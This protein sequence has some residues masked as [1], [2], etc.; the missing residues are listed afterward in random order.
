MRLLFL[1][2]SLYTLTASAQKEYKV[3]SNDSSAYVV[4]DESA[5]FHRMGG[6]DDALSDY[7]NK[8]LDFPRRHGRNART[9]VCLL[10]SQFAMTAECRM[11]ASRRV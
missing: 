1:F 2:L 11:L 6:R 5:V 7:V 8:R 3:Y 10:F 4:V 9:S